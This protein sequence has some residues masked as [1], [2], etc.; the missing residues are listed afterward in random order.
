MA[1]SVQRFMTTLNNYP[2]S[3]TSAKGTFISFLFNTCINFVSMD[4]LILLFK[5]KFYCRLKNGK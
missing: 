5:C 2:R 3:K 4:H 1:T